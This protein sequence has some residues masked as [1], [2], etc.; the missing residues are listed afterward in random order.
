MNKFLQN[1]LELFGEFSGL[2]QRDWGAARDAYYEDV[3]Q[4]IARAGGL[5]AVMAAR[6]GDAETARLEQKTFLY[7]IAYPSPAVTVPT[8]TQ[9]AAQ[10]VL[11]SLDIRPTIYE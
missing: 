4:G 2:R 3:K 8:L 11:D 10:E 9:R 1:S 5:V 7:D 6:R